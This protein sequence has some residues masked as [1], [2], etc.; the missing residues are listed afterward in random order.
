MI[1]LGPEKCRRIDE[2][3]TREWLVTN[4]L[5]GYASGTVPG[6][7]TR[8]YHGLLI[9]ALQPP[10]A[11]VAM[12]AQCDELITYDGKAFQVS[13]TEWADGALAPAGYIHLA[14]FRLERGLPITLY[15]I[16]DTTIEKRIWM[17]YGRHTTYIRYT[18]SATAAA[19]AELV[20]RPLVNG[21]PFHTLTLG[22]V[23]RQPAVE[24]DG[25]G[26]LVQVS[27]AVPPLRLG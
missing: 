9:A 2:A 14:E 11:R 20:L 19:S 13:T 23:E 4:G 26:C 17:A 7:P 5:G 22:S 25:E 24:P 21:R 15:E 6:T 10:L 1:L 16:G 18:L 8:R 27:E 3:L 12:L